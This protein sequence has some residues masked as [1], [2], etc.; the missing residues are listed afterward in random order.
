V[1]GAELHRDPDPT[2]FS[3]VTIDYH[4]HPG[5]FLG[6]G[7]VFIAWYEHGEES[8][9][10]GYWDSFPIEPRESLEGCPRTPSLIKAV[11]WGRQRTPRL[12]VRP[13]SDPGEYYWAGTGDPLDGDAELK[14]LDI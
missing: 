2:R 9:Y 1:V 13:E 6:T 3:A 14:K 11:T 5:R 10:E 12:L 7:T 8:Y 4:P